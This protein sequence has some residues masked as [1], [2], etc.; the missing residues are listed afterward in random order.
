MALSAKLKLSAFI[1]NRA[2]LNKVNK[3]RGIRKKEELLNQYAD[4]FLQSQFQRF[5]KLAMGGGEW[6]GIGESAEKKKVRAIRGRNAILID[7]MQLANTL[8]PKSD[9]SGQIRRLDVSKFSVVVGVGGYARYR[10]MARGL[11]KRLPRKRSSGILTLGRLAAIHHYGEG[12]NPERRILVL[13]DSATLK[14]MERVTI[15]WLRRYAKFD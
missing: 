15:A 13:P 6:P 8:R 2:L 14:K 1:D 7:T 9:S 12:L 5:N 11:R 10:Q 3:L 4:I